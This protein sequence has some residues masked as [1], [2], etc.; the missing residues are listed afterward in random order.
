M[1]DWNGPVW[2]AGSYL[3]PG[4]TY[5]YSAWVYHEENSSVS[6]RL[7]MTVNQFGGSGGDWNQLITKNVPR[8]T[9]TELK[10]DYTVKTGEFFFRP[11]LS[12]W[13]STCEFYADDIK[14]VLKSGTIPSS[15]IQ[16]SLMSVKDAPKFIQKDLLIGIG[17]GNTVF[18]DTTGNRQAL[19]VKHFNSFAIENS[20]KPV[21][22]L[23]YPASK[24]NM[25]V[26]NERVA[27]DFTLVIP[28]Y[29][30]ALKNNMKMSA[31]ALLWF[32]LTPD[33]F[34]RVNYDP[35][36]P[37][38]GRDL[39]LKRMEN[40]IKDVMTWSQTNYPGM[41]KM[42]VVCNESFDP[43]DSVNTG[44]TNP[45]RVRNDN[46]Y[47]TVGVDY[48]AKAFE[49]AQKYKTDSDLDLVYNDYNMESNATKLGYVLSYIQAYDLQLDGIG[50][51]LH[52]QLSS[53]AI[54]T[55][56]A[57]L[58]LSKND[59]RVKGRNLVVYIS[60]MDVQAN[61]NSTATQNTLG[62]RYRDLIDTFLTADIRLKGIS[63][64]CLNDG[65]TWLTSNNSQQMFPLLFDINNQAKPAYYGVMQ[66]AGGL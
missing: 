49:F 56:K 48:V 26:H 64:W 57:N 12:T 5:T 3:L 11:S 37:L 63:W 46:W 25:G 58:E 44:T 31:Q 8:S 7:V 45:Y 4:N 36:Q 27:L 28:Y 30:F 16:T 38:A 21:Y 2:N 15:D 10:A 53:P 24:A 22:I 51:Q 42:W 47:K 13:P 35:S 23:D 1:E 59:N 54:S 6:F 32:M 61:N 20:F 17:A 34:F 18:Q 65:Y 66:A 62:N 9:W 50:Y 41:V 19:L 60:E 33:W 43:N 40:F 29:D 39:M 55:I 14:I 52:T